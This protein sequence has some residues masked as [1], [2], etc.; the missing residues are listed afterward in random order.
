MLQSRKKKFLADIVSYTVLSIMSI[1]TLLPFVWMLSSSLKTSEEI[2]RSGINIIPKKITL[3]NFDHVINNTDFLRYIGNSVIVSVLATI[4]SMT[5]ASF[6]AYAIIRFYPKWGKVITRGLIMTYMFP[7]IL[8]AIP[9]FMLISKLGLA[10]TTQGLILAYLSF[11]VPFCTW[12]LL[13]YFRSVPVAVEEAAMIDGASRF[14]TFVKIVLPLTAPGLV[15]TG[16]FAFINAWNEFLYSLVL[17]SS[18]DKK[19]VSVGLYSLVGGETLQW[20]DMMAASVM[21]VIPSLIFFFIIQRH[22]ASGLT[23]GAVKS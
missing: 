7:P 8:L 4:V 1:F 22:L 12:L 16:I 9:Y 21:V 20:G 19:T 17:I 13:G 6:A 23:G 2:T 15:A 14:K 5:L 10:N 18:G 11:T 3:I